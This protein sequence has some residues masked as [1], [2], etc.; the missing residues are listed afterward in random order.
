MA[1]VQCTSLSPSLVSLPC[2]YSKFW[3]K[4]ILKFGQVLRG[5]F[6]PTLLVRWWSCWLWQMFPL[7]TIW[8]N[9]VMYIFMIFMFAMYYV[10][11]WVMSY[12]YI[13]A[14]VHYVIYVFIYVCNHHYVQVPLFV[15]VRT[16]TKTVRFNIFSINYKVVQFKWVKN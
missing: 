3:S 1:W 11:Y 2:V 16:R 12:D 13:W 15:L 14:L 10:H 4:T 9:F 7:D 5:F 8:Y 6:S